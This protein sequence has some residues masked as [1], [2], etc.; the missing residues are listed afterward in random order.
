MLEKLDRASQGP[1]DELMNQIYAML[2]SD[3]SPSLIELVEQG[4]S[5]LN[6][7][8]RQFSEAVGIQRKSLQR[9][10]GGEAKKVDILT[11]LKLSELLDID[12]KNLIQVYVS[13]LPPESIGELERAKKAGFILRNFDVDGLKKEGVI[14]S[15]TDFHHIEEKIKHYFGL[16][17]LFEYNS[18]A[19]ALFSRT[20]NTSSDKMTR[21]WIGSAYHIC[22]KM[23]N[24]NPYDRQALF[25]MIPKLRG[26][27][28]DDKYGLLQV[29][30][31]LYSVGVSVV[32]QSYMGRTQVRGATFLT[33]KKPCIVLADYN[34]RYDTIWFALMHE[35]YHV[36]KDLDSIAY[37]GYHVS[38][39]DG[40]LP[41]E[42]DQEIKA[43]AFAAEFLLSTDKRNY[44]ASFID[45]PGLVDK[46]A[47]K[48][49]IH[50]SII[51]GLYLKEK[52]EEKDYKKIRPLI[53]TT[54]SS[55]R[56]LMTHPW[57]EDIPLEVS[58]F[59]LKET[60]TSVSL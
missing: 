46:Y 1:G 7:S 42:H 6:V 43:N 50:P 5:K 44:I 21:F 53:A 40:Q 41:I 36:L 25:S 15:T 16:G 20:K 2:A 27:T 57:R 55:V 54:E 4:M 13:G 45:V 58:A 60:L 14:N 3:S 52:G 11:I 26:F 48:W 18:L 56:N 23:S 47:T 28:R 12:L 39:E 17:S 22:K 19:S 33:D 31:A 34:K 8:E 32:V 9:I 10:L 24:P 59:R 29:A 51:Y 38:K 35:I 30:R 49:D 37:S